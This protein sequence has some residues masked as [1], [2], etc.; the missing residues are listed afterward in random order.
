[1]RNIIFLL[2]LL[3]SLANRAQTF[4]SD[5]IISRSLQQCRLLPQEKLY[6]HTDKPAYIAGEKVWLRVHL[7]DGSTHVPTE[8]SRYVYIELWNSFMELVKRVKL[9]VDE[10]GC[11]YGHIP[12]SED[13]PTGEYSLYA[14][15]RYM[16]NMGRD[17]FFN[18]KLFVNNV[19]NKSI[20]M[21]TH[22]NNS[23]L[24]VK[25]F[26]PVT[27]EQMNLKG[28]TARTSSGS[29]D[30]Q[31]SDMDFRIKIHDSKER[32]LLI[33]TGNYKEYVP[34]VSR[35]DYDVSFFPEGGNLP[36]GVPCRVAFKALNEQGQGIDIKGTVRDSRDTIVAYIRNAHR[37]MGVLSFI[38]QSGEKYYA[39]CKDKE[40]GEKRF[41]FPSPDPQT[42]S[43]Q[44]NRLKNMLLVNVQHHPDIALPDSFF[45]F[46]HQHG[47]PMQTAVWKK[48]MSNILFKSDVFDVG[49]VS[50]L[51]VD[52]QG[53]I[54]SERMVFVHKDDLAYGTAILDVA[55]YGKREKMTLN[56]NVTDAQGN[57][58]SG[59]CSLAIT[60]NADVQAD[61]CTNI[62]STLLITSDLKG[63]IE[64]P[65]WYFGKE[66][67]LMR[68][69][70]LDALMMTQ[71]WRKYDWQQVW[72]GEYD[73]IRIVPEQSQSI[74]GK[75]T[76]RISREPVESAK[77][78]IMSVAVGLSSE[79]RTGPA[80]T[81]R[82]T[83][84]HCPDST[85]YWLTA[86][87]ARGKNN[88]VLDIDSEVFPSMGNRLPPSSF[89]YAGS[90]QRR[91]S[92]AYLEKADL[93]LLQESGIRHFF[94]DE[95][96][97][98]APRKV[99]KTE[100]ESVMGSASI[101]EEEIEK[102]GALDLRTMLRQKVPGLIPVSVKRADGTIGYEVRI[103]NEKVLFIVDGVMWNSDESPQSDEAVLQLL[104]TFSPTNIEQIDVIKG[105][106]SIAYHSKFSNVIAITTKRGGEQY[107]AK[108]PVTN[109]KT[110]IPLGFQLPAEFYSPKYDTAR[111]KGNKDPDLRTTIYWQPDVEIKDGKAQIECYTS[112]SPVDYTLVMEGVGE[113]GTLLYLKKQVGGE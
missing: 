12:L 59:N 14:Y 43:L 99:Y 107:N 49:T 11:I 94:L 13:L 8:V 88:I 64:E 51:L 1:M 83:G 29:V 79:L 36:S 55:A 72:R 96:L 21:E 57:P 103:R 95:V 24:Y 44:V 110:I 2:L 111:K 60:D 56:L 76:K 68:R 93:R 61:S 27:G 37:G 84:F 17:Y 100:Y 10:E 42:L 62:L 40:G 18:K 19:L 113:D 41:D 3:C 31:R 7:V 87:T 73:T 109:L 20:R 35:P 46:A 92:S 48:G 16:E 75:V 74:L 71:G 85:T 98:T 30:V 105:A 23:Y 69:Q 77:V 54:V 38:P 33:Q 101:K 25:F 9:M 65:A 4:V 34:L 63:Y 47:W 89:H 67:S 78:N 28:C 104:D 97:V 58:W 45:I 15:T 81:F 50:F 102:S 22:M 66:D 5:S 108:W 86:L 82:F 52:A 53:K 90:L 112:D 70:A 106:Q 91:L 39:I 26:H 32:M 80:G 6:V